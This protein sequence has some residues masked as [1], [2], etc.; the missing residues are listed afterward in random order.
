MTSKS[1]FDD[2]ADIRDESPRE[3]SIRGTGGRED[4]VVFTAS[5]LGVRCSELCCHLRKIAASFPVPSLQKLANQWFVVS[6][7]RFSGHPPVCREVGFLQFAADVGL[8]KTALQESLCTLLLSAEV[9]KNIVTGCRLQGN[10]ACAFFRHW[11]DSEADFREATG[12]FIGID[13]AQGR[14]Q[15]AK[16]LVSERNN[17]AKN[18]RQGP[19]LT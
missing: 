6:F 11:A 19:G 2:V 7:L 1:R 13:K 9:D 15:G 18:S 5:L 17:G 10:T 8:T 12:D 16:L 14:L 4:Q 3:S